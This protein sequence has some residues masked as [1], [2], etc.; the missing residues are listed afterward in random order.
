MAAITIFLAGLLCFS[1]YS[2]VDVPEAKLVIT[3]DVA[4]LKEQCDTPVQVNGCAVF[5]TNTVYVRERA[6]KRKEMAVIFHE[7]LHLEMGPEHSKEFLDR[8]NRY[9][10]E[11]GVVDRMV[12]LDG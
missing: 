8:D 4:Y 1:Q 12:L 11:I 7:L 10:D 2:C 9:R 3:D 5:Q 6:D